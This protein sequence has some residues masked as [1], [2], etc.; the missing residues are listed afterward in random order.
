MGFQQK[1][2]YEKRDPNRTVAA[3]TFFPFEEGEDGWDEKRPQG[4]FPFILIYSTDGLISCKTWHISLRPLDLSAYLVPHNS[5]KFADY[6]T[7]TQH[8]V[9]RPAQIINEV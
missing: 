9:N 2:L 6:H 8:I 5:D 7:L 1:R 3:K 4:N